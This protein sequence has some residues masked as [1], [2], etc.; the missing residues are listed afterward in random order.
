M[1]PTLW[2]GMRQGPGLHEI[3]LSQM[4]HSR[5]FGREVDL[6]VTG[7]A[8][9]AQQVGWWPYTHT[10]IGCEVLKHSDLSKSRGRLTCALHHAASNVND[11]D[12]QVL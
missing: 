11:D 8:E 10:Y 6:R 3:A 7:I 9:Q 1:G 12:M 2:N 4:P 5:A